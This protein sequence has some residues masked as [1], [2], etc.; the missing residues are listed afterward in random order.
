M[1][2]YIE[3]VSAENLGRCYN[4]YVYK[5]VSSRFIPAD[6]FWKA[7]GYSDGEGPGQQFWLIE[8]PT[9]EQS[10]LID[11]VPHWVY[12]YGFIVDSSD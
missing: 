12:T 7:N 2:N 9:I 8:C 6:E 3:Q 5:R 4:R 10:T 1:A 11:G